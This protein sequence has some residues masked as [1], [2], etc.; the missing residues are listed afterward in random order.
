MERNRLSGSMK[1]VYGSDVI[2][3]LSFCPS[4]KSQVYVGM[5]VLFNSMKLWEDLLHPPPSATGLTRG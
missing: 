3:L 5:Y 2:L 4:L 1:P